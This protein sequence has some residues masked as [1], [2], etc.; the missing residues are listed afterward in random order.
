MD[1]WTSFFNS[2]THSLLPVQ[3]IASQVYNSVSMFHYVNII[4]FTQYI[5]QGPGYEKKKK[6]KIIKKWQVTVKVLYKDKRQDYSE[7]PL[8]LHLQLWSLHT[9][10][11][12]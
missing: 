5:Y 11:M 4:T 12:K 6:E 2:D 7:D 9:A 10:V 8:Q 3:R 1:R